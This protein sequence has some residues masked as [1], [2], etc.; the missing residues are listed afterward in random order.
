[1]AEK[2]RV[3]KNFS[4]VRKEIRK[5]MADV[6]EWYHV[7]KKLDLAVNVQTRL[8]KILKKARQTKE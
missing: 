4:I 6:R 8:E 3:E 5:L 2:A 1:M 7:C